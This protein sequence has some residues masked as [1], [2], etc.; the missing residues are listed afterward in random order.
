MPNSTPTS[1]K[2]FFC[3]GE[4]K[5]IKNETIQEDFVMPDHDVWLKSD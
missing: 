5:K 2:V 3:M 1:Y 4:N